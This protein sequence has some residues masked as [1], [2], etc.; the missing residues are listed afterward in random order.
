VN[1]DKCPSLDELLREPSA[2]PGER[3]RAHVARCAGCAERWAELRELA[4]IAKKAPIDEAGAS[5]HARLREA[6]VFEAR[7]GRFEVRTDGRRFAFARIAGGGVVLAA[8]IATAAVAFVVG[9]ERDERIGDPSAGVARPAAI[10]ES[11]SEALRS[12]A[13]P[14]P[15]AETRGRAPAHPPAK[16][17]ERRA[18]PA[19][20]MGEAAVEDPTREETAEIE[21]DRGIALFRREDFAGAA[22]AL[23]R[24]VAAAPDGAI[25][26]DARF[27]R[28]LALARAGD[29]A[30][31]V[32]ALE[33]FLVRHPSSPRRGEASIELGRSLAETGRV[34]E[35]RIRF[36]QALEDDAPQIRDAARAGLEA[37]RP[38]GKR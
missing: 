37:L 20:A 12:E 14:E 16:A 5:H 6:I 21:F 3:V 1:A 36:E 15:P 22:A 27:E 29:R 24:S 4:M 10:A 18:P 26:E 34:E 9:T 19:P 32:E 28:A 33:D 25:A 23:A 17:S 13:G 38:P 7:R 35:A 31:A 11:A 30:R 2:C 8:A